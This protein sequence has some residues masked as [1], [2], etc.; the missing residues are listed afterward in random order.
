MT[1]LSDSN[2]PAYS[3]KPKP[4]LSAYCITDQSDELTWNLEIRA[5]RREDRKDGLESGLRILVCVLLE[6]GD[7]GCEWIV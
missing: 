5:W 4:I 7:G 3:L 1:S 6:A 2:F